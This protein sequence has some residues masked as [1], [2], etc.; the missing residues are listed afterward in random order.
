MSGIYQAARQ[1]H[2]PNGVELNEI[3]MT[4]HGPQKRLS[5]PSEN[6]SK[7]GEYDVQATINQRSDLFRHTDLVELKQALQHQ[8]AADTKAEEVTFLT[9]MAVTLCA[10]SRCPLSSSWSTSVNSRRRLVS[11]T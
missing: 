10:L 6:P 4:E 3:P 5:D 7:D 9:E 1:R 2:A 8:A 11:R